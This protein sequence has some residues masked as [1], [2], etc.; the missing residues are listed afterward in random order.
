MVRFLWS[1]F[2]FIILINKT[3][4]NEN[5]FYIAHAGGEIDGF[6]YT[7]SFIAINQ[8]IKSG[9]KFIEIDLHLT[10]D[11]YFY[12]FHDFDSLILKDQQDFEILYNFKKKFYNK[13]IL[14]EDIITLNKK[15]KYPMILEDEI[16]DIF[17]N[18]TSLNLVTD[19]IQ[20][21]KAIDNKFGFMNDR[22]FIEILSKKNYLRSLFYSFE[23][24]L[25]LTNTFNLFDRLFIRVLKINNVVF[26]KGMLKMREVQEQLI[27]YRKNLNTNFFVYTVNLGDDVAFYSNFS[28]Y[29]YTDNL[30]T[31]YDS[32]E[33]KQN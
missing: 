11:E 29:I 23:N 16:I 4:S 2:F 25:F 10:S 1:I 20:N 17:K 5:L 3:Y 12:G 27:D 6:T 9:Y 24:R 18:D 31:L 21:F 7:N 19:K 13:S 26:D 30:L 28:Q 33:A 32:R 14:K 22:L 15:L 8:S